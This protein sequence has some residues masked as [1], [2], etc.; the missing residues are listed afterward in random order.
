MVTE[1]GRWG[2]HNQEDIGTV[3][4]F[5]SPSKPKGDEMNE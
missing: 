5:C 2:W 4:S 1:P 3:E